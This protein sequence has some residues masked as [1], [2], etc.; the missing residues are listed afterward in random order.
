MATF[1]TSAACASRQYLAN[2]VTAGDTGPV[3]RA[4]AMRTY[5]SAT[6]TSSNADLAMLQQAGLVDGRGGGDVPRW[7]LP[8]TKTA[9]GFRLPTASAAENAFD[10]RGGC[11]FVRQRLP[12]GA[13]PKSACLC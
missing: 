2:L 5:F 10:I 1:Q 7:R 11:G 12:D 9:C 8:I 6:S 3:V 13:R 4:L